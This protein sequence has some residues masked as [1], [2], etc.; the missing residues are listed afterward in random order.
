MSLLTK[1]EEN[2]ANWLD[3]D[4]N[5]VP[6]MLDF[7]KE[8]GWNAL[9]VRLFV[10]PSNA[11]AA[12]VGQGVCQDLDYVVALGK[13]IK[14]AGFSLMLDLHYSDSWAD[15]SKQ[16]T[17]K[18]WLS[19][20]DD[21]LATQ[22]YDYTLSVLQAMNDADAT[23]DMVQIGN[24]IS[25]GMMWGASGTTANR[26]YTS[27]DDNWERFRKLLA[28]GSKACREACPDAKI[29]V[30]TERVSQPQV[31][32]GIYERLSAIDYDVIGLSYYPYWHGNIAQLAK[33][34]N[35]LGTR[36]SDKQ[37]MIVET[38]YYH[39]WQPSSVDYDLSSTYP[40][41]EAGQKAFA[42]ALIA[43]LKNHDAVTGLF[44]WWPEAC[45]Y[46]L[47]WNTKRVTDAWYNAGLWDNSTGRALG[48]LSLL[49][50][51]LETD[52]IA[53][54]VADEECKKCNIYDVSGRLRGTSFTNKGKRMATRNGRTFIEISK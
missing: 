28:Q 35:A 8:R 15:P 41:T 19:L 52:G 50:T 44:W 43:E 24:E 14:A 1:Y 34:L 45:E 30:H 25:Y 10:D 47:D 46:G 32:T 2:G 13:R 36:F 20:D 11:S 26:C 27:S 18:A 38:G 17:P 42:E 40:I 37:I 5:A 7:L 12:D 31:L 4:G 21:A 51:F 16:W 9:R 53:S 49:K 33:A 29:I 6:S 39:A 23:P 22:T 54:A 48:A 3:E